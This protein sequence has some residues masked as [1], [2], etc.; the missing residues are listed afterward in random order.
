MVASLLDAGSSEEWRERGNARFKAGD[1]AGAREAYTASIA[2]AP[3]CLAY[4]NRAMAALKANDALAADADAT[5]AIGLDATYLKAYQRRAAARQLMGR[6]LEACT[7]VPHLHH[8]VM[9][10]APL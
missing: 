8:D 7:R 6:S 10:H 3:T 1:F 4:A 9:P 5:A 2:A